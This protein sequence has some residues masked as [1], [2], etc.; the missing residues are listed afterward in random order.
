MK[1][2]LIILSVLI[3]FACD[4]MNGKMSFKN[5]SDSDI[6]IRIIFF[7]DS[8]VIGTMVGLRN[9]KA[10]ENRK[11][12]KLYSWESEFENANKDSLSI[13]IYDN[14]DFL[15]NSDEQSNKIK[16]DSLLKVGDFE[17]KNYTLKDLNRL[18]WQITYPDDGFKK[19]EK[20]KE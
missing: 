4:P 12:G 8:T 5:E 20:L 6:Y 16:S 17:Y 7:K 11:I 10:Y 15:S 19:G 2:L 14:Y 9:I 13:V 18:K 1:K 3:C